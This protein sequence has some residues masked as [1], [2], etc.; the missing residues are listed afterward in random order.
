MITE[1]L[2]AILLVRVFGWTVSLTVGGLVF[3]AVLILISA[4]AYNR[5]TAV[6]PTTPVRPA[7]DPFSNING[8][9]R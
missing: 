9:V 2:A 5:R 8:K 3:A 6:T 1:L 7:R 4:V